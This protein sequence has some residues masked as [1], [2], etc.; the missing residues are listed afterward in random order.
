[1]LSDCRPSP[2]Q[3]Q[4]SIGREGIEESGNRC[5]GYTLFLHFGIVLQALPFSFPVSSNDTTSLQLPLWAS[6]RHP[7]ACSGTIRTTEDEATERRDL[8][9]SLLGSHIYYICECAS[10]QG[11]DLVKPFL[12]AVVVWFELHPWR[13]FF[14]W[15]FTLGPLLPPHEWSGQLPNGICGIVRTSCLLIP[16]IGEILA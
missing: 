1:V 13:L 11:Q 14:T 3:L 6:A 7:G 16:Q 5:Y 12:D 8:D 2:L 4:C 9:I 15:L 10:G